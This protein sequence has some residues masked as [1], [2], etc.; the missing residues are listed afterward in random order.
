MLEG[1]NCKLCEAGTF[2][3]KN[4]DACVSCADAINGCVS[5]TVTD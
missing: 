5:C 3:N 1:G 4:N 2:L